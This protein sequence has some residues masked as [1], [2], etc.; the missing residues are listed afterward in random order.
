MIG[1]SKKEKERSNKNVNIFSDPVHWSKQAEELYLKSTQTRDPPASFSKDLIEDVKD[2]SIGSSY[3]LSSFSDISNSIKYQSET[4][5]YNK[6]EHVG[7]TELG[8]KLNSVARKVRITPRTQMSEASSCKPGFFDPEEDP[9][10]CGLF[11]RA[12]EEEKI[13]RRLVHTAVCLL[14]I[15]AILAAVVTVRA[16]GS[17]GVEIEVG[18]S[19]SEPS[20]APIFRPTFTIPPPLPPTSQPIPLSATAAPSATP[21]SLS[22]TT[23]PS[24]I[25]AVNLEI[26]SFIMDASPGSLNALEDNLSPQSLALE[27]LLS[28]PSTKNYTMSNREDKILQRWALAV[29][30]KSTNGDGWVTTT[31]WLTSKDEC[32]W[33]STIDSDRM[34]VCDDDG[35]LL[36]LHLRNNALS[37][38]LPDEL[39]LL[40]DLVYMY[41]ND[42]SLVGTIPKS[43]GDLKNLEQLYLQVNELNGSLPEEVGQMEMLEHLAIGRNN[44]V[45]SI[46]NALSELDNLRVLDLAGN[47]FRG[48]IPSSLGRLENLS[49]FIINRNEMTGTIPS[50]LGGLGRLRTLLLHSN[51][52]EGN[53]PFEVCNL[54]WY[55]ELTEIS[56][57]CDSLSCGCGCTCD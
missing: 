36:T 41:L 46:P 14:V 38:T 18:L 28:D 22:T 7:D 42:G 45:G 2:A 33:Y 21:S 50:T 27:W 52:F 23:A 55:D 35:R 43:F 12:F 4:P 48:S 11:R 24:D 49:S 10:C 34:D 40:S 56:I 20:L 31:N 16:T 15:F 54:A 39:S 19:N 13:F 57:D 26:T 6:D 25:I 17:D 47:D 30:F 9:R 29:L 51:Q 3:S 5:S 8:N 32:E 1:R 37:G 44:F 53:I